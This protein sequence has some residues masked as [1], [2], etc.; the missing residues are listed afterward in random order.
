MTAR[1]FR[2]QWSL[3][4]IVSLALG[5]SG[6]G[7]GGEAGIDEEIDFGESAPGV[8]SP[9]E[10][11]AEAG[12]EPVVEEETVEEEITDEEAPVAITPPLDAPAPES[13][14]P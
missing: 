8:A 9:S 11:E 12:S 3:G 10:L 5:L 1:W 7:G 6:C 14:T 2:S 4:W 13:E